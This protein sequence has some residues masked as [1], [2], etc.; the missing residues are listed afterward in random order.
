ME[1]KILNVGIIGLGEVAQV[2]HLPVLESLPH[3]YRIAALCDI[4]PKLVTYL[5][6]KYR[7]RNLYTDAAQLVKQADLD[8]VFVLNSDEYHAEC[9]IAA[10]NNNKHVLIEKPMCLT[11]AEADAIIEAQNKNNVKVLVGYMRRYSASFLEAA[12]QIGGIGKIQYARVRDIIGPNGYFVKPTSHVVSFDDIPEVLKADKLDRAERLVK[13]AT[14][15][16]ARSPYF[17]LYRFL[18]GLSSHDLSLMRETLG[19]PR[20]VVGAKMTNNGN[21]FLSAILDYEQFAVTFETGI[22]GQGRFDAHLEVYA[23]SKSVRVQY[24]TPYIRHLPVK[25]FV[26]ETVGETYTE[27]VIR[28]TLTDPYTLELQYLYD[29]ITKDL[30]PKTT[31][32]DY[33]EDL[34]IFKMIIDALK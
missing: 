16:D 31:P 25:I 3:Q 7:V 28:P 2:I 10:A 13:E 5:G 17:S 1:Q 14:G 22:D 26:N 6:E 33:K 12:K 11:E 34:A 32:E 23:D 15:L 8:V 29:V 19:M 24:D 27:S 20:G 9:A 21:L 18:C 4:S 30:T